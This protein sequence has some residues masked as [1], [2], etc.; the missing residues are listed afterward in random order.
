MR[1]VL[2]FWNVIESVATF[3][4]DVSMPGPLWLSVTGRN[5]SF[6]VNSLVSIEVVILSRLLMLTTLKFMYLHVGLLEEI[7]HHVRFEGIQ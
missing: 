6:L 4:L 1:N 7:H 5:E 3:T 2:Q